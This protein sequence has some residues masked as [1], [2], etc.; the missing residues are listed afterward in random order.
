MTASITP[1]P[2][3]TKIVRMQQHVANLAVLPAPGSSL[4]F[5][6][7][8]KL[9]AGT[10]IVALPNNQIMI[11]VEDNT[12]HPKAGQKIWIARNQIR[13]HAIFTPPNNELIEPPTEPDGF[14]P[15]AA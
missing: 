1:F 14:P 4:I 5:M 15:A 2:S 6:S 13:T 8:R 12:R 10:V 9:G 7:D 11:K 3:P